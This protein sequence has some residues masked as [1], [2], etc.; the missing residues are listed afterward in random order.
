MKLSCF[1]IAA[2][3]E[4]EELRK[5]K[6]DWSI[7]VR[8]GN[9][10]VIIINKEIAAMRERDK[11]ESLQILIAPMLALMSIAKTSPPDITPVRIEEVFLITAQ[12]LDD[13][14]VKAY[15]EKNPVEKKLKPN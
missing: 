10:M 15:L 12:L 3:M 9:E 2:I 1:I 5:E 4:N 6:R 13:L 7:A 8:L 14:G 11:V